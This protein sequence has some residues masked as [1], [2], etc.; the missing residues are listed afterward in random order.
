MTSAAKKGKLGTCPEC[1]AH[2]FQRVDTVTAASRVYGATVWEDGT[3]SLDDN[4][5]E[6]DVEQAEYGAWTCI[7]G[8]DVEDDAVLGPAFE[9]LDDGEEIVD[10]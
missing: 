4:T 3:L 10:L 7:N 9:C 6:V 8:H 2:E 1:G 5:G